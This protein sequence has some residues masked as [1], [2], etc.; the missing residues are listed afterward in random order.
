MENNTQLS[1]NKE[2]FHY[3]YPII[4]VGDWMIT[5]LIMSIPVLNMIM[6]FIWG[7]S[8][9]SNPNKAN[10]AKASLLWMAIIIGIYILV[11]LIVF[12]AFG[13]ID[14]ITQKLGI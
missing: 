3:R 6:L 10:W 4:T 13:G 1:S 14:G 9:E 11:L 2:P 7:F 12:L 5:M 8:S